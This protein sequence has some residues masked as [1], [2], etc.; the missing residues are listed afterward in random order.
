M[1]RQAIFYH[2]IFFDLRDNAASA[3]IHR[4]EM[5]HEQAVGVNRLTAY[6]SVAGQTEFV[7]IAFSHVELFRV[8]DD[9]HLP[10][11]EADSLTMG[12]I[13]NHF[14]YRIEGS[15]FWAPQ[16]EA[17]EAVL[18]GSTHYR[19]VTGGSCLDVISRDQPD[20]SWVQTVQ[21]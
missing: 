7:R 15:P 8:I 18:P 12:H 13:S 11:E 9:M 5:H 2:P 21:D 14:A 4:L 3:D 16:R 1:T 10:L 6:I 17:F 20:I 19:F